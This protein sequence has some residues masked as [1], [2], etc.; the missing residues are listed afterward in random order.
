MLNW[1]IVNSLHI[2]QLILIYKSCQATFGW[3]LKFI[4][5]AVLLDVRAVLRL[6]Q[7][8]VFLLKYTY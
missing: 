1:K 2:S 3:K 5:S 8:T 4:E 6:R 7:N